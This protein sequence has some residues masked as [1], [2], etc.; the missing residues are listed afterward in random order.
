MASVDI[1]SAGRLTAMSIGSEGVLRKALMLP[2]RER[3]DLAAELLASLDEPAKDDAEAVR[4][5]W[6][7][8]LELRARRSL[9]GDDVGEP[10]EALRDRSRNNLAR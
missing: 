3:A 1:A 10:W 6:A 7:E 4:A 2:S 9:S 5:A 8:E